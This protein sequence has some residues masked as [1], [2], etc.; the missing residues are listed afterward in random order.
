MELL[1][2]D[3]CLPMKAAVV[4]LVVGKLLLGSYCLGDAVGE[5]LLGSSSL[6]IAPVELLLGSC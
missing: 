4:W 3:C 6:A 5:M 1:P 2:E